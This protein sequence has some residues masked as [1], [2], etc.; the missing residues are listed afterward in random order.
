MKACCPIF[1]GSRPY[2]KPYV[3][4]NHPAWYM[5]G[6]HLFRLWMC[7]RRLVMGSSGHG[8]KVALNQL[9]TLLEHG[10]STFL[11]PDGPYGPPHIVK[12]GVLHL[13]LVSGLPIVAIRIICSRA[14]RLPTWD[15]KAFPLPGS[16]ITLEYSPPIYVTAAT[17]E[18][19]REQISRPLNG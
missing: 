4:M 5:K 18:R 2:N 14:L 6:V 7:V 9:T 3:W 19:V 10:A 1:L 17:L 8:G 13:S 16:R 15:R 11:N 12:D